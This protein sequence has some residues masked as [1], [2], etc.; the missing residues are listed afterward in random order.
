[1]NK[2]FYL[3][4]GVIV[5]AVALVIGT[6]YAYFMATVT[7]GNDGNETVIKS[8]SLSLTLT[9][10]NSLSLNNA[11]PGSS[12]SKK[13]TVTNTGTNEIIYNIKMVDVT[14]TF[15]DK[16][17]LVYSLK[18]DN[19]VDITKAIMPSI[20][21]KYLVTNILIGK[22]ETHTYTL[23]ITFKETN[24]NQD[25]NK[26]ATFT[27]KI[28]ID[29]E[30]LTL[31]ETL[32]NQYNKDN[33]VGLVKDS[34][35]E[36]LYYYTGTNEQVANNFLWYGGHQWRVLEFDTSANTITLVT[37]QPLTAIQPASQV[38]TTEEEYN[39]SY[40][41]TWL[42]DYFWNSLDSSI[43]NN[44]LDN[45]FNVGIYTDIDEITTTQKVGL[46]D[47]EQ[48]QRAGNTDSFLDIKDHFWLGNRYGSSYVRCVYNDD[49]LFRTSVSSAFGVRAVIK[50]S[51]ITITE[52]DGT[53]TSN[54]QV[55]NKATD[56]NNVQVGEYINVPYS[57]SDSA[58]GSD[59]MCTFRVVS[60]DSD[61]IKV[62]LNGL[63]PDTSAYGSSTTISTSH[64]IY[65]P[66]NTFVEGISD[67]YRYTGNKIFYIGDYPSGS[68]YKDVQN[69]TLRAS[70]G[71]PTVGEMFSGN[72]IDLSTS[73][74]KTFVDINT[75]ENPTVS[76]YY[77][78]MNG[79]SSS[80]VRSVH[81]NGHLSD[82]SPSAAYGV[83]AVIY[84]K[85]GLTFTGGKGTAQNPYTL[86]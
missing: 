59:N 71:L 67:T 48:Y 70:V 46:L 65:T 4:I 85:S 24:D 29:D 20:S 79:Y 66:L 16:S 69:E 40:I 80:I 84:L 3:L 10:N 49:R 82:N 58:C 38:W 37:Q 25:D 14:N 5:V 23:T 28:N 77:W 43:Q 60:K 63:L 75:I 1:M 7:G 61:S 83:R 42:K 8:G 17:D 74:T 86:D 19:G 30:R 22:G 36:N 18:G 55:A 12:A 15:V 9:D 62:V 27:G 72:D 31:I 78:T 53:L 44:I 39:T 35:N 51:D 47:E 54:Y 11:Q 64:T 6:S 13:F 50:I 32:M 52:G 41:N 26:N 34:T 2:K 56:T 45:T 81:G 68:N 57:G 76:N 33:I 21:D 73:S